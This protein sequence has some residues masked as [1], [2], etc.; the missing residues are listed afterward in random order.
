MQNLIISYK[1][2]DI[3]DA[4][5]TKLRNDANTLLISLENKVKN[6][7]STIKSLNFIKEEITKFT[8]MNKPT[9]ELYDILF[10]KVKYF[11]DLVGKENEKKKL[12][13]LD[14][15][16]KDQM[17]IIDTKN[18]KLHELIFWHSFIGENLNKLFDPDTDEKSAMELMMNLYKDSELDPLMT[19]ISEKKLELSGENQNLSY[20]DQRKVKQ[21][22]RGIFISKIR[23]NKI[24]LSEVNDIVKKINS[25]LNFSEEIPDEEYYFSYM[26][27]DKYPKNLKLRM[28]I[29][30]P[31]DV[32]Y[33]C[34]INMIKKS[35]LNWEKFL[36]E[37]IAILEE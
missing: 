4:E 9:K 20:N 1:N 18:Y 34:F 25:R 11:I 2:K 33:I 13:T 29:F 31:L 37:L 6:K 28:P 19:F 27:S 7:T 32:F 23:N 12:D 24:D 26:I 30:E 35:V 8:N 22:L 16:N 17:K 5:I 3:E 36:M 10:N 14:L 21:M 15:P